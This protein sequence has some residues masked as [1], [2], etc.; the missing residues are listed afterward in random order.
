MRASIKRSEFFSL[1]QFNRKLT[2]KLHFEV[3]IHK[4]TA[5]NPAATSLSRNKTGIHSCMQE[6]SLQHLNI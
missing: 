6:Q 5:E 2:S 3:K 1:L 4:K